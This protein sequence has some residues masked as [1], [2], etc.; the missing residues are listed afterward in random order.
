MLKMTA[1]SIPA[2]PA[3]TRA[4]EN[5]FGTDSC[6]GIGAGRIDEKLVNLSSSTK[7]INSKTGFF[8]LEASLAFI[9]LSKA[10]TKALILYYFD[11][12]HHIGIKTNTLNYAISGVLS[13]LTTKR[14]LAGQMI[15]KNLC[16]L[17]NIKSLS[18]CQ[19]RWA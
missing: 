10:F 3:H 2:W 4:N 16:R 19:I 6:G 18:S 9:G 17:I 13:Q 8:M 1:L 15:H 5:E 7:K 12:K 14:G 11:P